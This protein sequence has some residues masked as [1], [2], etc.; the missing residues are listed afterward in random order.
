VLAVSPDGTRVVLS[1]KGNADPTKR[2]VYVYDHSSNTIENTLPISGATAAAFSPDMFK[3]F[4]I[5]GNQ[6]FEYNR[7]LALHSDTLGGIAHDVAVLPSGHAAFVAEAGE[8]VIATCNNALLSNI[9]TGSPLFVGT[10]ANAQHV[11][12]VTPPNVNQFD[13]AAT[14]ACPPSITAQAPFPHSFGAFV[15]NQLLMTPDGSKV[16]ILSDVGVLVYH[17]GATADLGTTSVVPLAGGAEA[18][19]GVVTLDSTTVYVGG[20]D[21]AVHRLDLTANGGAGADAQQ[22]TGTINFKP[23][24]VALRVK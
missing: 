6:V 5:A 18:L 17:V 19:T 20:S 11:V 9:A 4:I 3:L 8:Q 14:G 10:T 1:D 15:P 23:D 12:D 22:I 16:I 24:I 7:G 21:N 2:V 13:V